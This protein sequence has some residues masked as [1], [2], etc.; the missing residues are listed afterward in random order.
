MSA[1]RSPWYEEEGRARVAGVGR[2][3]GCALLL[4]DQWPDKVG[5]GVLYLAFDADEFAP[6]LADLDARNVALK[7]GWRG[8]ALLIVEDPDSNQLYF[9]RP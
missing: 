9:A 7:D 4:T 1:S 6:V 5:T 8:K 3:D 2:G